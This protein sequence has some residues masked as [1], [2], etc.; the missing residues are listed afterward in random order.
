L[1]HHTATKKA[2]KTSAK[3]N[4]RNQ[5]YKSRV[6]TAL[7]QLDAAETTED[8]D[9]KLKQAQTIL[10]RAAQKRVVTKQFAS[11]KISK[12]TKSVKKS[13]E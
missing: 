12:L 3:R 9:K 1:A 4:A 11:R 6:K 7:K 13:A 8:K 5:S 10:D 2:I